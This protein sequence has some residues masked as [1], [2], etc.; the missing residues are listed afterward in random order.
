MPV[1][2]LQLEQLKVND[3]QL[4][5]SF[6]DNTERFVADYSF[7]FYDK[8]T[9]KAIDEIHNS[10]LGLSFPYSFPGKGSYTVQ[11]NFITNDGKKSSCKTEVQLIE[12]S[13]FNVLYEVYASSPNDMTYRKLDTNAISE[14]KL[15]SLTEIPT[16]LKLKL[17]KVEPKTYNTKIDIFLNDKPVIFTTEG[18]YI[19]DIRSA[20]E[21]K[22]KIQI[23]DKVRGLDYEE[24]LTAKIGLED[25]LGQLKVLGESIGYEPFEI[26][27]DASSSRLN[28]PDDQLTYFS[29]DFGDGQKQA[30]VSN[31]VIKHKYRFDYEKNN[32]TFT[33]SVTI[34]TQK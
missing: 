20:H 29:W 14:K 34:Y 5:A 24:V 30:K 28:D 2:K 9:G 18:E 22:I 1:C 17:L 25:I 4:S 12:K 13:T 11:M 10:D 8:A 7:V 31:G 19:F 26:T 23:Q 33:P 15:I 16:K 32:G 6:L 21:H 27:L 3:Y